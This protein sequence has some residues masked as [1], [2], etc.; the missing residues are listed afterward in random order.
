[1]QVV[2]AGTPLSFE[3]GAYDEVGS[4]S[5]GMKVY[6]ITSIGSPTQ[7]GSTIAM[8]HIFGGAY[9]ALFTPAANKQ[10]LIHK[11]VYTDGSFTTLDPNRSPGVETFF[12]SNTAG[13]V[14]TP[15]DIMN[16][17]DAVWDEPKADH[18][19]ANTFGDY[20]DIEVSSRA[21]T[22]DISTIAGQISNINSNTL[23]AAIGQ[24]VWG[25]VRTSYA[26]AGT[27]GESN[28][29][30]ITSARAALI[31]NLS[32]LDV[33][34]S[35]R[36]TQ[37]SVDSVKADTNYL[38]TGLTP[39]RISNL[40][41]LDAAVST[42]ASQASVDALPTAAATAIAVWNE[43]LAS[44]STA[45]STGKKLADIPA[46]A[47]PTAAAVAAAV[48]NEA[49]SG[50][51]TA[52]TYGVLVDA[53]VSSRASQA[54][55]DD[56]KGS[57]FATGTDSLR[58]IRA[59]VDTLPTTAGDATAANQATILA[60]V[61][62]KASQSSVNTLQSSVSAIPTNPVLTNDVRI[63]RLD[64]AV[65]TRAS[66]ASADATQGA[67]FTPGTDDLHAIRQAIASGTD[68]SPVLT[69]LNQ[70]KGSG[71]VEASDSLHAAAAGIAAST[72]AANSAASAA[73]SAAAAVASKASQASVN[74]LQ[75][76]VA[77]IP[78]NPAL[79]TD[80]RFANL[81]ATVSS[82]AD[83]VT[84]GQ[85]LGAGYNPATDSLRAIR[86]LLSSLSP[87][88]ATAANQLSI[89]AAIATLATAAGLSSVAAAVAAIPI[90]PV[91]A[92]DVR[93]NRIDVTV[94]SR[95]SD[96]DMQRVKGPSFDQNLDNLHEIKGAVPP[97]FN[98]STILAELA[99][100][101]GVG[102]TDN[103][104]DLKHAN[105]QAKDERRLIRS[106]TQALLS[107]GEP[108]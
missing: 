93:L 57:G 83:A 53:Q 11:A 76:S 32:R 34:V 97:A 62:T 2:A 42:R 29:G 91:L 90:N 94:S 81:D 35:T 33:V 17:A 88:D 99:R 28:Q 6:D 46:T 4:L 65:S 26:V 48:W 82:R 105:D 72:A 101:E 85:V 39:T 69:S 80:P 89:L 52:G 36:S 9:A 63:G 31:D 66:Q 73:N 45:G 75:A 51:A 107:S 47:A 92:N 40:D 104:D 43:P 55:L 71:Y 14:L 16:I 21:S 1:M 24:S 98:V 3:Y 30:N 74:T 102:F 41:R 27:F 8:A 79:A 60:A 86:T 15:A 64:V 12:A 5:V 7:V 61:G 67:G 96:L 25:A 84:L 77:A 49:T 87:G 68:L 106:D 59:K 22:S 70:I 18:M 56:A 58:Q 13:G 10:Y 78:T 38:A 95:A 20:L 19:T 44:H 100:I 37:V 50:H 54:S 23:P 108:F 103:V